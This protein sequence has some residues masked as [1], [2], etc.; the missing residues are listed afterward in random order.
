ML[1]LLPYKTQ[2]HYWKIIYY[3]TYTRNF[4]GYES[5]ASSEICLRDVQ[6]IFCQIQ[7]EQILSTNSKNKYKM[8]I[9]KVLAY[10][11][12]RNHY[13]SLVFPSVIRL[14]RPL[15]D[16]LHTSFESSQ[17]I[18]QPSMKNPCYAFLRVENSLLDSLGSKCRGVSVETKVLR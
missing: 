5:F 10:P 2:K 1:I 16:V 8:D 17:K 18:P 6:A 11:V 13:S 3:Y 14:Q 15:K 12:D 4:I 7:D 9:L